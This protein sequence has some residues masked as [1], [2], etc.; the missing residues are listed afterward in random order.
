MLMGNREMINKRGRVGD[1]GV[2]KVRMLLVL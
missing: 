1:K 2:N